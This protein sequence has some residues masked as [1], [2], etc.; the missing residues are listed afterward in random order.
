M[1]ALNFVALPLPDADADPAAAFLAALDPRAVA[2]TFQTFDDCRARSTAYKQAHEGRADPELTRV[3]NGSLDQHGAALEYLNERGAGIFV[4]INRTDLTG[5][6]ATNV[7]EVRALYLDLDGAPLEPVM[8]HALP[9]IIVESSP[10]RFH[11]YYRVRDVEL[12]QFSTYQKAL[13]ARFG[14]DRSVH[15]LPRVMRLPGFLHRKA[16]PP[17]LSRLVSINNTPA[18][19]AAD[20]VSVQEEAPREGDGRKQRGFLRQVNEAA[21]ARIDQWV[22]VAF[23]GAHKNSA[24]QLAGA[25]ACARA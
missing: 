25:A 24:G 9:H 18:Y 13:I 12:G 3:L 7:K 16:E 21:L 17:F 14:G 8:R 23:P 11:P 22:P 6:K 2:W 4:T 20:I 5:R 15:D 19:A 10:D 1:R